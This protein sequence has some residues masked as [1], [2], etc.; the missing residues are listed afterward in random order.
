M[1]P[2]KCP[3]IPQ[4]FAWLRTTGLEDGGGGGRGGEKP[5]EETEKKP[6]EL[7][8][9]PGTVGSPMPRKGLEREEA[10]RWLRSH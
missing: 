6:V 5:A 4:W 1:S 10:A 8:G 7:G 3:L 2:D 9:K